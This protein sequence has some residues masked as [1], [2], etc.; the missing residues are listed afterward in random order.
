MKSLKWLKILL[1]VLVLLG[2]VLAYFYE[3]FQP[4]T[5][6]SWGLNYSSSRARELG[7]DP[8]HVYIDMLEDLRPEYLRLPAYWNEI[9]PADNQFQ[10]QELDEQLDLAQKYGVEVILTMG[11]KAPRWPECHEPAWVRALPPE[12]Q[13]KQ[14]L[15][16]MTEVVAHFKDHQAIKIWQVENEPLFDFGEDC[17]KM[18]RRF[19]KEAVAFVKS[20]D[21]RPVLVTDSGELGRWLPTATT[22]ADL[23]GTTMYRIVHNEYTG[24]FKYPL[25]PAFFRIKAGFVNTFADPKPQR[26][27]GVELQAEPWVANGINNTPLNEQKAMMN[28]KI[29]TEYAAYAQQAGFGENYLWGVEWWYWMAKK[30]NDWGMWGAAKQLM[31]PKQ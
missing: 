31:N 2:L 27:I 28:P 12:D 11:K 5:E 13:E 16:M 6:Y 23:F 20:L 9:E 10:F 19:L 26:I 3:Q 8:M 4:A 7:L 21:S 30:H 15:A 29:F 22:G 25:P 24:F 17:D 18:P 14:E 1:V